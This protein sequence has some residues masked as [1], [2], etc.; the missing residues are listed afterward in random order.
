M[1][2]NDPLA[3]IRNHR[4]KYYFQ[5][6]LTLSFARLR[7]K[8]LEVNEDIELLMIPNKNLMTPSELE[9][10]EF[11]V[12][13]EFLER[14]YELEILITLFQKEQTTRSVAT[15]KANKALLVEIEKKVLAKAK[16]DAYTPQEVKDRKEARAQRK[17]EK[18]L[19]EAL[20]VSLKP[21]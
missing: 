16:R 11:K 17:E 6:R 8:G 7:L 15:K 10:A 2:T 5:D 1:T 21:R 12:C 3:F 20:L 14:R 9:A 19:K 4:F 13:A 18:R